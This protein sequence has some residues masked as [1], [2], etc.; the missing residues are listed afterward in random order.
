MKKYSNELIVIITF[1]IFIFILINR[2]LMTETILSSFY[3]W[4]NT[5]VPSMFPMIIIS[6]ILILAVDVNCPATITLLLL[7]NVSIA[8]LEF[9]SCF[10]HSSNIVSEI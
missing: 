4:Y 2:D 9:T 8:T 3:I 7:T 6:D 10:K 5:L 1:L